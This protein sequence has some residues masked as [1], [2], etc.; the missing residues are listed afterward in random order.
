MDTKNRPQYRVSTTDEYHRQA[1]ESLG[2][3]LTVSNSLYPVNTP[4][5]KVLRKNATYGD[6]LYAYLGAC[7]P[8]A[9]L[10]RVLEV[11]GGYGYL[12]K[13]FLKNNPRIQPVMLDISPALL[14]KQEETLAEHQVDYFL[15]D[16]L[17]MDRVFL[18]GFDLVIFNENLGDFPVLADVDPSVLDMGPTPEPDETIALARH[19]FEKYGLEK[20]LSRFNLNVGAMRMIE[21]VCGAE[22]PYIFIGEHSCEWQ[23]P[24][25]LKPYFNTDATGD[26]RMIRLKGH[27]EYTI[28]FSYLQALADHWGYKARRGPFADYI[29]PDINDHVRAVLASWGLYSDSEE[30]ICQFVGDLYEYEYLVL[31][32]Q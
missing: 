29:V 5:R 4:I 22:V 31:T 2:W 8:M 13:D 3:E 23:V 18:E 15:N 24:P 30:I 21:K 20:P 12:M 14:K 17:E 27:N 25:D 1:L 32:R 26:P 6:L 10:T 9:N 11:G 7:I 28:K 16:A 19:F